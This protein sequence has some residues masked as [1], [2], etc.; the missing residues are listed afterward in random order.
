MPLINRPAYR[1][2]IR[3]EAKV[4][5]KLFGPVDKN[6]RREFFCLDRNTWVW[7]EEWSDERA[8][9][10]SVTT[11]YDVRPNGIFKIQGDQPHRRLT[12]DELT[13]FY[14]AVNLYYDRVS[15]ELKRLVE[16]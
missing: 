10:Q 13:N 9:H 12:S 11:R 3:Y 6:R 14:Q 7:H 8:R 5:G 4:G 15:N 1:N 2:I 16:R